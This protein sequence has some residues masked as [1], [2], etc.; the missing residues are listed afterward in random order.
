MHYAKKHYF[1]DFLGVKLSPQE[2]ETLESAFQQ[3]CQHLS[4]QERVICHRD[5]HSRN[6][7]F[8][9]GKVFVID[10]QDARMGPIHYDLVSLLK[11]SYV[12]LSDESQEI[13]LQY[14]FD[15]M[16]TRKQKD[17]NN[18]DFFSTY[19][20][21]C[22]QRQLKACGSFA[23]FYNTREDLRYLKYL[24]PTTKAIL[25]TLSGRE[26]LRELYQLLNEKILNN[27]KYQEL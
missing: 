19:E 15:Q 18:E 20:L 21:Q 13:L 23:S 24:K 2:E 11:D 25:N 3:I 4:R 27:E 16:M 22:I 10:F 6:V 5:Y 14:Y 17:L 1:Q 12:N 9:L 8:K 7:M 26:D